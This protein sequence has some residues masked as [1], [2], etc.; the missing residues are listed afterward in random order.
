METSI[1]R[2]RDGSAN[3]GVAD[4][5]IGEHDLW[6]YRSRLR[7]I[8]GVWV[9]VGP[10]VRGF[11]TRPR[12]HELNP[13]GGRDQRDGAVSPRPC[14]VG[15]ACATVG[16]EVNVLDSVSRAQLSIDWNQK[17]RAEC[18]DKSWRVLRLDARGIGYR[19]R[20]GPR[21]SAI[22]RAIDHCRL[23]RGHC[24]QETAIGIDK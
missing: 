3:R 10:S 13:A 4:P 1:E 9:P 12:K 16:R 5:R 8:G 14:Q 21:K 23:T 17:C 18:A 20:R 2:S 7:V 11:A 24:V 22:S 15:P 19:R 6:P